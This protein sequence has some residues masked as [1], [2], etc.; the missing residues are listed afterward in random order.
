MLL[1]KSPCTGGGQIAPM[2]CAVGSAL[3]LAQPMSTVRWGMDLGVCTAS[4]N[5]FDVLLRK[6]QVGCAT[7]VALWT[8]YGIGAARPYAVQGDFINGSQIFVLIFF[9]NALQF[10]FKFPK[11]Y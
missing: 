2:L 8:L 1:R 9:K 4:L 11:A 3:D 5:F 6:Y 10:K 7:S